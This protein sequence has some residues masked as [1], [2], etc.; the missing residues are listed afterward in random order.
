M[1]EVRNLLAG[2]G[3]T[4]VIH[5]VDIA[6]REGQFHAILG[7]NGVGKSTT[8][9]TIVGLLPAFGGEVN[10]RGKPIVGNK[11]YDIAREG[12]AYVPETRDIFGSLSVLENLRLAARLSARRDPKWTVERVF[13]FFPNLASRRDN[14]G[15]QLSGGEQQML[16]IGRA[17]VMNPTLLILDEPTE[18]LAPIIVRQIFDKLKELKSE[19]MTMLLVEQ[20]FHFATQLTETA[21]IFGRGQCVWTGSSQTLVA[22]TELHEKWLGV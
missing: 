7:R 13:E 18:G 14:G 3:E 19:G 12:I 10:F 15:N 5:G 17:L 1:L 16:A 9:K 4:Q 8:L 21:S 11:P 6:V 2:Y 20:N 22:D